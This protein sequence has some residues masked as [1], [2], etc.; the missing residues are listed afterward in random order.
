MAC[1]WN[2]PGMDELIAGVA[3]LQ[4]P[5]KSLDLAVARNGWRHLALW[6]MK[7]NQFKPGLWWLSGCVGKS[8]TCKEQRSATAPT[9]IFSGLPGQFLC[10]IPEFFC[11]GG[12]FAQ[13][14][15]TKKYTGSYHHR[16]QNQSP[17]ITAEASH[18]R[19][20]RVA[21]DVFDH[22]SFISY[23][24]F[25][26]LASLILSV[27]FY[28]D[29]STNHSLVS[30]LA[31]TSINSLALRF[32]PRTMGGCM[33]L[34]RPWWSAWMASRGPWHLWGPGLPAKNGRNGAGPF[35]PLAPVTVGFCDGH[36]P[37]FE[38][39]AGDWSEC[40]CGQVVNITS[41]I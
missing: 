27:L 30:S 21:Y 5:A 41:G 34:W 10:G 3:A 12:S 40:F 29:L 32:W 1:T 36:S 8:K 22:L 23:Q 26:C 25:Y 28:S 39:E 37:A 31:F 35:S 6:R 20:G 38:M 33:E 9:V 14:T 16:N 18:K 11:R 2:S 19:T 13:A 7:N 17:R 24:Y 15:T 4:G